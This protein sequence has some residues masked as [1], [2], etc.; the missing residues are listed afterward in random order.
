M[1]FLKCWG[2]STYGQ[3][4]GGAPGANKTI[5][6]TVGEPLGSGT[7][8]R[9]AAGEGHT[10]AVLSDSSVQCWG[11]NRNGQ[12]GGG[13]PNLGGKTATEIAVGGENA[14]AIL[15][16]ASVVCWGRIGS[17]NLGSKT[18]TQI[19]MG[20]QHACV[21]LNDK[22]VKCWG[23]N[24]FGQI[25]GGTAHSSRVLR[26][27]SGD[28]LGGQ[29][30]IQ[31]AAGREFSCAIMESDNS[32]KCWGYN[33]SG[34]S[35]SYGK[36]IGAVAMTGGLDGTGTSTGETA[37]LTTA[38]TPTA[39]SL[40]SDARGKI[41]KL[42]LSG[43][44]L[45][46]H[47]VAKNY[48]TPL[49]Y[50][51]LG[52]TAISSVVSTLIRSIGSPVNIAGTNVRLPESGTNKIVAT[53]DTAVF[54][55][56]T[57]TIYHDDNGGNCTSSPV[58]TPV[59][60]SGASGG[61]KATGLWVISNGSTGTGDTAV[62]LDSV[63]IDLGN[64]NLTKEEIADKIVADVNGASWAGKQ[65]VDLPYTATKV[66]NS[67]NSDCPSGD[68]CVLFERVFKGTE[69]NYGIPFGDRDYSH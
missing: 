42:T 24:S 51:R 59:T 27:T 33:I 13:T 65:N 61:D 6:G 37:T 60:L 19:A 67:D 52:R 58:G 40:D 49:T 66:Q 5:S 23:G 43:G 21:I 46:T 7:A 68:F 34:S 53:T 44:G 69:G 11:Y 56:M 63:H 14:C 38:S 15:N 9:I 36:I 17:P 1:T 4:G 18:V 48:T 2:D 30:A 28:P 10:C 22:S 47:W 31:I 64:S 16:D 54:D 41:C 35:G 55:G 26:G 25:G 29:P 8:G 50:N 20:P 39:T 32:V 45:G 3:I 12:T 57:L 62:N